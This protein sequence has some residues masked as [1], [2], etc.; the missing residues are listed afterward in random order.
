MKCFSKFS[1]FFIVFNVFF[2]VALT[3]ASKKIEGPPSEK[4]GGTISTSFSREIVHVLRSVAALKKMD[5]HH[6]FMIINVG[7]IRP[8]PARCCRCGT[9]A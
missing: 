9:A 3:L 8:N 2:D 7:Q 1:L 4:K 5:N 6:V